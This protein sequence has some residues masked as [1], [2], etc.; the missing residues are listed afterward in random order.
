MLNNSKVPLVSVII[1]TYNRNDFLMKTLKS[2]QTQTY[3]N[4]EIIVI[5]D[6]SEDDIAVKNREI[7]NKFYLCKYY[8]KSNSGQP[9]SRNYG[10]KKAKGDLIGFCDDDDIWI[11]EKLEKQIDIFNNY[12]EVFIVTGD[13]EYIT[14]EGVK[15]GNV[16]SH[17]GFN[18]GQIF[19][20]L[21]IKNRTASIVPLLKKAVFDKVGYFN[22]DFTIAEDWEFWRRVSYYFEF[23]AINEVLAYVRL[24]HSTMSSKRQNTPIAWV[25]LYRKLT[26]S[27]LS[28]GKNKF[29]K[30]ERNLIYKS[31]WENH[32]K[33]FVNH[34]PNK[35]QKLKL[36]NDVAKKNIYDALHI[37][38]L[39]FRFEFF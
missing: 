31:E 16:K 36:L 26:K 38:L 7:C 37:L 1:T 3:S 15:T 29:D 28:W 12:P 34:C 33:I 24:H 17:R 5:D 22:P 18:H 11:P 8:Y 32:K 27:L 39:I 23:Y 14:K 2:I 19:N 30:S 6:G 21:L 10:L 13:T 9:D 25:L 20:A 4:L 35:K